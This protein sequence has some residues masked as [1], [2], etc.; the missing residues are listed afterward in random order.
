MGEV[1]CGHQNLIFYDLAEFTKHMNEKAKPAG[2][3]IPFL[4]KGLNHNNRNA[5]A[6]TMHNLDKA[7]I[8]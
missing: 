1:L 3:V 7:K 8:Q 2:N 4:G 6:R 5:A